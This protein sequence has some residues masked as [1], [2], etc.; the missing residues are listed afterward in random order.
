MGA[1]LPAVPL[2][3]SGGPGPG[4]AAGARCATELAG[5]TLQLVLAVASGILLLTGKTSLQKQLLVPFLGLAVPPEVV[6]WAKS[7]VGLWIA[8]AG[9]FTRIFYV[10]PGKAFLPLILLLLIVVAPHQV[11]S[12]RTTA[13]ANILTL[14]LGGYIAYD[15]FL[16]TN[17]SEGAFKQDNVPSTLS[18]IALVIVPIVTLLRGGAGRPAY[19]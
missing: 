7:E 12:F 14:I 15:H 3:K 19:F 11:L 17:G 5:T 4:G 13:A 1:A 6:G 18:V 16:Q 10:I 9:L 2:R 8:F